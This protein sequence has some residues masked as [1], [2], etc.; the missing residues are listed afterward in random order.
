MR[1]RGRQLSLAEERLTAM[2]PGEK[3]IVQR[4]IT[5]FLNGEATQQVSKRRPRE[6]VIF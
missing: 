1:A 4:E 3:L 6:A 2:R 5:V